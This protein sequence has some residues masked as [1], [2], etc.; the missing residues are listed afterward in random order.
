MW[1]LTHDC[2]MAQ[3]SHVDA[4]LVKNLNKTFRVNWHDAEVVELVHQVSDDVSF[5]KVAGIGSFLN[6]LRL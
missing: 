2:D 6:I 1:N 4:V 5:Q 3:I